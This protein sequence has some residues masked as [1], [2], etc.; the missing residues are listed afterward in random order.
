MGH[1]LD[2]KHQAFGIILTLGHDGWGS[3]ISY[4]LL[5]IIV[6]LRGPRRCPL[7]VISGHVQCTR[8]CPLYRQKRTCAVQLGMS[9]LC[10][11]RTYAPQQTAFLFDHLVGASEQ[12]RRHRSFSSVRLSPLLDQFCPHSQ[13]QTQTT[14]YSDQYNQIAIFPNRGTCP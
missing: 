13:I 8:R 3:N 12:R 10:Q 14:R 6:A 4:E 9:A 1:A 5:A 11:K 7:W 2:T